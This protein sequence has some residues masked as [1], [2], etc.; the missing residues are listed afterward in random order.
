MW[1]AVRRALHE[2]AGGA[3]ALTPGTAMG[4]PMPPALQPR[5]KPLAVLFAEKIPMKSPPTVMR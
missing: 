1:I 5:Q 4:M 2:W 3:A